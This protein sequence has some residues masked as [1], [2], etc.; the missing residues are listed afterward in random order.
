MLALP[1][2]SLQPALRLRRNSMPLINGF[3]VTHATF[4]QAHRIFKF[5]LVTINAR[6]REG[7]SVFCNR[8]WKA[9][10]F[11]EQVCARYPHGMHAEGTICSDQKLNN[12]ENDGKATVQTK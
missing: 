3:F 8:I 9:A 6:R 12:G 10:G 7:S 5:F 4:L 11:S 2:P 1:L